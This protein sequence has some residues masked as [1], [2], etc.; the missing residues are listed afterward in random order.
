[1]WRNA[2]ALAL[3]LSVHLASTAAGQTSDGQPR[4]E[5]GGH[6][7]LLDFGTGKAAGPRVTVNFAHRTALEAAVDWQFGRGGGYRS[8]GAQRHDLIAVQIMQTIV[9][10]RGGGLFATIGGGVWQW[11]VRFPGVPSLDVAPFS[12]R[13]TTRAF[14]VGGGIDRQLARRLALRA[15][16]LV[17]LTTD[18]TSPDGSGVHSLVQQRTLVRVLVGLTVPSSPYPS[19]PQAPTVRMSTGASVAGLHAGLKAW[20]TTADGHEIRGVVS[21]FSA[22]SLDVKVGDTLT[23]IPLGSVRKIEKP[24]STLDGFLL[25]LGIG[26]AAGVVSARNA[27]RHGHECGA[28]PFVVVPVGAGGGAFIG[29][30]IDFLHEGRQV[31]YD[32]TRKTSIL[33]VAPFLPERGLGIGGAFR[34]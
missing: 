29:W 16:A 20:V 24:D 6:I 17:V 18:G 12:S 4:V 3:L 1:M 23:S 9:P 25:G 30:L 34:W 19:I 26:A 5:V 2:G 10:F 21:S 14:V 22:V 13:G 31:L 33:T 7:T 27:C 11:D 28:I 15:G 8:D 32:S